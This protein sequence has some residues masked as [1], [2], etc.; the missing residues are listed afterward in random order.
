M[1]FMR[2][3]SR[4]S[5]CLFLLMLLAMSLFWLS[6]D[7]QNK[8]LTDA[9]ALDKLNIKIKIGSA[10]A[11]IYIDNFIDYQHNVN[12]NFLYNE[13]G[14]AKR[15]NSFYFIEEQAKVFFEELDKL[16]QD[17][18][19]DSVRTRVYFAF[20]KKED[21]MLP[22]QSNFIPLIELI[23]NK[24]TP[25]GNFYPVR[26][27]PTSLGDIPITSGEA[28]LLRENWKKIPVKDITK[29]LYLDKQPEKPE[30]RIRYFT[31]KASDTK[32]IYQHQKRLHGENKACYVFIHLGQLEALGD[33]G[34]RTIIHLTS[35]P[36]SSNG[37]AAQDDGDDY[38]EF[39]APCP[40]HC[41]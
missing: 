2:R 20:L 11:K 19:I 5:T 4:T 8:Q 33:V 23:K 22:E 35:K 9:S 27:Y 17:P 41:Q 21:K 30:N 39:S 32:S 40:H 26:T 16:E 36:N 1:N 13:E 25:T 37:S 7:N 29:Q 6:C 31:F 10:E 24:D 34:L 3:F 38:Y 15:V 12:D 14:K 18:A 28:D